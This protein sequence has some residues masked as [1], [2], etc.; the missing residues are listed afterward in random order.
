M[1]GPLLLSRFGIAP[2]IT[3]KSLKKK[4]KDK[5]FSPEAFKLPKETGRLRVK[6]TEASL[7]IKDSEESNSNKWV[8]VVSYISSRA[9]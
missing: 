8:V 9:H 5:E 1:I 6:F 4:K 2:L 3:A 7:S